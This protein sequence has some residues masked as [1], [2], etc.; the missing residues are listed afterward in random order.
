MRGATHEQPQPQRRTQRPQP[1]DP[2]A[3][4]GVSEHCLLQRIGARRG[5]AEAPTLQRQCGPPG[6]ECAPCSP[7]SAAGCRGIRR[8]QKWRTGVRQQRCRRYRFALASCP[9]A[10]TRGARG[11]RV[12]R[13]LAAGGAAPHAGAEPWYSAPLPPE[14]TRDSGAM[15]CRGHMGL[16]LAARSSH[17]G[18]AA[19][20]MQRYLHLAARPSAHAAE[21]RHAEQSLVTK[22]WPRDGLLRAPSGLAS[23]VVRCWPCP[24]AAWR[25]DPAQG[26]NAG[27]EAA[28]ADLMRIRRRR[29]KR[30]RLRAQSRQS[31]EKARRRATAS[32]AERGEEGGEGVCGC[33]IRRLLACPARRPRHENSRRR[34]R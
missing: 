4:S 17:L 11:E 31:A 20:H 23:L 6:G 34:R 26:S 29:S 3:G 19:L 1:A 30:C 12:E 9:A 18:T 14:C 25:G 15:W 16:Q 5:A 10:S 32:V 27:S 21:Q 2:A 7:A 33:P 13:G 24:H 28:G 22:R 8:A